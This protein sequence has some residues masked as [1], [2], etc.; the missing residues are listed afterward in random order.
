MC[1]PTCSR[2]ALAVRDFLHN[3]YRSANV[4]DSEGLIQFRATKNGR[5]GETASC[6]LVSRHRF[7]SRTGEANH[8]LFVS[9]YDTKYFPLFAP[10]MSSPDTSV[11]LLLTVLYSTCARRSLRDMLASDSPFGFEC[12]LQVGPSTFNYFVYVCLSCL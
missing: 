6:I 3:I 12:H 2:L 10:S 11:F 4:S 5:P 1:P 7:S 9:P 8:H